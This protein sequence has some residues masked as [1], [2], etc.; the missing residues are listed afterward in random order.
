M[1]L[2]YNL[3][4]E[5]EYFVH[6]IIPLSL[7]LIFFFFNLLKRK[8]KFIRLTFNFFWNPKQRII[9]TTWSATKWYQRDQKIYIF[10]STKKESSRK[11]ITLHPSTHQLVFY[12]RDRTLLN[13]PN[14]PSSYHNQLRR[15]YTENKETLVL[16]TPFLVASFRLGLARIRLFFFFFLT[17]ISAP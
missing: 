12:L 13:I 4:L 9:N 14:P 5:K 3:C 11:E 7:L 16:E 2:L 10:S 17:C 1:F 8:I 15:R 6:L